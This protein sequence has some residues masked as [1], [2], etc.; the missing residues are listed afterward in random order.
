[1]LLIYEQKISFF[2]FLIVRSPVLHSRIFKLQRKVTLGRVGPVSQ[3]NRE[4]HILA[5]AKAQH[6]HKKAT[7]I[8]YPY[9]STMSVLLYLLMP[10]CFI[11]L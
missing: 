10:M 8:G 7:G 3:I 5:T 6:Y 11:M 1:M 4:A 9:S 2:L